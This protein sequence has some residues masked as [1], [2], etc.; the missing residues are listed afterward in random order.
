M[1]YCIYVP[2]AGSET[3]SELAGQCDRVAYRFPSCF[4][5]ELII[6]VF[7]LF[8][9]LTTRTSVAGEIPTERRVSREISLQSYLPYVHLTEPGSPEKSPI[10]TIERTDT[11][12]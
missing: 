3:G 9:P 4:L 6:H 2:Y 5:L 11:P 10:R 7:V 1:Y 12:L 8:P